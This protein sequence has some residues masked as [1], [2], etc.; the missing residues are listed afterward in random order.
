MQHSV[1]QPLELTQGQIRS[2][3][4]ARDRLLWVLIAALLVALAT[5][6]V[7][8]G[9]YFVLNVQGR[10]ATGWQDPL[11]T[12]DVSRVRPDIG[13]L[14]LLGEAP[15]TV[16]REALAAGEPD[17]AYAVLVYNPELNDSERSGYLLLIARAFED[18]EA[19]DLAAVCYQQVHSL[20][21]LSPVM[22]DVVRAESSVEAA[23]GFIRLGMVDAARPSLAQAEALAR[24]SSMLAPAKRQRIALDLVDLYR[25]AG[26]DDQADILLQFVR[27]PRGLPDARLVHGPFLP[28]FMTSVELP[29]QLRD[30]Q[31]RRRQQVWAFMEAWDRSGGS[32]VEAARAALASTLLEEDG[33]QRAVMQ[34]A[35][36]MEAR[37]S[38]RAAWLRGWVDWLTLKYMVAR[39][40]AGFSLVP[41]WELQQDSIRAD[42]DRA[43]ADLFSTY[44]DLVQALPQV[45]DV[46]FAVIEVL[47]QQLLVGRLGLY[48]DYPEQELLDALDE[49]QAAVMDQ[50]PLLIKHEPWGRG[51]IFRLAES[52]E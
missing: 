38:V 3:A 48:P 34:A 45:S 20:A 41:E 26:L 6:V 33:I 12:V 2:R 27:K 13:V 35:L 28:Q 52:F 15:A 9:A 40:G 19:P 22:A 47:R 25:Q 39:R 4:R 5:G 16:V 8:L 10:R 23:A 1:V 36:Q 51:W 7:A 46:D 50:L 18:A 11:A 42:L 43:Y 29:W 24:Y 32:D 49:R 30:V 14:S 21:A 17:T 44:D 31:E 37:L